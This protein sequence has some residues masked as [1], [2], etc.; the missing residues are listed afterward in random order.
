MMNW[1]GSRPRE[2]WRVLWIRGVLALLLAIA[3]PLGCAGVHRRSVQAPAPPSERAVA[4][5]PEAD[6][7]VAGPGVPEGAR[8]EDGDSPQ[9]VFHRVE[10]GQTL[11]RIARVYAVPQEELLRVNGLDDPGLLEVGQELFIPG[12]TAV[13]EV[14]PYPS[15]LPLVPFPAPRALVPSARDVGFEWPVAGGHVLSYFGARRRTHRHTGVD[16]AGERGQEIFAARAGTVTFSGRTRTG[17]GKLVI[18]DHGNGIES[19]YAHDQDLLVRIGDNVEKGQPIARLGRSG[20]ATTP[21][22]HFEI[23]KDRVPVDPL[24]YVSRLAEA[25]P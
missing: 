12:A 22:C 6:A 16:I 8:V 10:A 19:L 13:L 15:P 2:R 1:S 25:R 9:G 5:A 3:G 20:N 17:Y 4:V 23:R 18:L 11:W 7:A 14:P 21:H 24:L